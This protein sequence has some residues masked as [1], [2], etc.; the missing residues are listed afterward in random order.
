MHNGN[1]FAVHSAKYSVLFLTFFTYFPALSQYTDVINSNRPGQSV[2]AYAVGENVIQLEFGVS[3]EQQDHEVLATDSNL[4]GADLSLRYGLLFETLELNWE[5]TYQTQNIAYLNFGTEDRLTNFSR[6][7]LGLKYLLYDPYKNTENN[8]P[9]LYSWR[10]NNKF[11]LK[12]LIPAV[13]LYGGANFNLGD[14][15]FYV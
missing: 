13:S 1:L 10:A 14:N 7:R 15:P 6:N 11:R 9:N 2:S 4:W 12:N 8:K 3:Y 5:G